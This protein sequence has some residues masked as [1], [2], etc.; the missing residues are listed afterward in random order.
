M[1]ERRLTGARMQALRVAAM[2]RRA[3]TQW[4]VVERHMRGV[5]EEAKAKVRACTEIASLQLAT[6]SEATLLEGAGPVVAALDG[7]GITPRR[8]LAR[9]WGMALSCRTSHSQIS[10]V[11]GPHRQELWEAKDILQV[12]GTE[13][14]FPFL[15]TVFQHIPDRGQG[16]WLAP[17]AF[18]VDRLLQPPFLAVVLQGQ[19]VWKLL[20]S[21]K[22]LF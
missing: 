14:T 12:W 1:Q 15:A 18:F 11:M 5:E 16:L 13:A 10:G 22:S 17:I 3:R 8:L 20:Y 7:S 21:R 9:C 4:T 19:S 6:L 2:H